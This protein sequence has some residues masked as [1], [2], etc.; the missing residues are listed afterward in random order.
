[1]L[2]AQPG[3][4]AVGFFDINRVRDRQTGHCPDTPAHGCGRKTAPHVDL[5]LNHARGRAAE[6]GEGEVERAIRL[7]D[8]WVGVH[9]G[10]LKD[11][12]AERFA[13]DRP[14]V[15]TAAADFLETFDDRNR[16]AELGG[17]IAA[18]SPPGPVPMAITSYSRM[19]FM[20]NR[21]D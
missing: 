12:E 15:R 8:D 11:R 1:M 3:S 18:P 19:A 16:L 9:L 17:C 14:E 6:L 20:G 5:L 21:G 2:G 13:G 4:A 7:A 10:H